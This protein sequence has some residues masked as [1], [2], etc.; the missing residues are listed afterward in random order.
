[1]CEEKGDASG[2]KKEQWTLEH[3]KKTH[4]PLISLFT[5]NYKYVYKPQELTISIRQDTNIEDLYAFRSRL[6]YE[7]Q[8]ERKFASAQIS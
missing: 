7:C 2:G 5:G 3:Y 1:M 8:N 4:S 6:T